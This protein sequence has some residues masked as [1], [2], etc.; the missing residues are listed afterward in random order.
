MVGI[1]KA[2]P[3]TGFM[4]QI[5]KGVM[6]LRFL[7]DLILTPQTKL[8]KLA[9]LVE[10]DPDAALIGPAPSGWS[11]FV[12]D[13]AM[14]SSNRQA[15]AKYFY[16]LFLGCEIPQNSALQ[17]KKFYDLT[18]DFVRKLDIPPEDKSDI[19]TG[20]YTHLKVDQSPSVEV[21][22]FANSY[23][24]TAPMRDAYHAHWHNR[25]FR[26]QQPSVLLIY[27]L[28]SESPAQTKACWP[29]TPDELSPVFTDLGLS[30]AAY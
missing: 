4:R 10:T 20:L 5:S 7:K 1:I 25:I 30:F 28:A 2:E 19:L 23:L 22:G 9:I 13:N 14:V 27:L 21:G 18:K 8:Y 11:V 6:S 12:Y 26:L 17:T 3:H 29:L 15:A 24:P 16:E